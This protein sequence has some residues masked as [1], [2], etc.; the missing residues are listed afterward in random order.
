MYPFWKHP[1]CKTR[2]KLQ[3]YQAVVSSKLLYGLE[4]LTLTDAQLSQ[5]DSFYFRGLRQI[6]GVDFIFIDRTMTN[7]RLL[8]NCKFT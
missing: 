6:L 4:S 5:L 1:R 3:V 2:W 7:K 8:E